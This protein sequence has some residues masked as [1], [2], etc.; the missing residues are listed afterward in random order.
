MSNLSFL[1]VWQTRVL[2]YCPLVLLPGDDDPDDTEEVA[3]E[4]AGST[5]L[6]LDEYS[7]LA[8]LLLSS[9]AGG[10]TLVLVLLDLFGGSLEN[11]DADEQT[12]E[13]GVTWF[14]VSGA[15]VLGIFPAF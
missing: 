14:L 9:R 12:V 13:L 1:L 15:E 2:W 8:A 4:E 7:I 6:P 3:D 11:L 10:T 5:I